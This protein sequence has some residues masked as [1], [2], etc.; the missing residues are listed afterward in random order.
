M[1]KIITLLALICLSFTSQAD[2]L[3]EC[4]SSYIKALKTTVALQSG[5]S[6]DEEIYLKEAKV[7]VNSCEKYYTKIKDTE[8]SKFLSSGA[9]LCIKRNQ[10]NSGLAAASCMVNVLDILG[11]L[12]MLGMNL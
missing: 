5:K 4:K 11:N 8:A 2:V 3:S 12:D 1:K 10:Q 9:K 7:A 6:V